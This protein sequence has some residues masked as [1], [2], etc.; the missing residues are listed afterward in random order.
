[1]EYVPK[2]SL[3]SLRE[4]NRLAVIDIL[5]QRG[6]AS[7]AEISRLTGLSRTTVSNLVSDLQTTGLVVERRGEQGP[8]NA[9]QGGRPPILLTLDPSAGAVVGIDFGHDDLRVAVADLSYTVLA[10]RWERFDVDN[11]SAGAL[12]AAERLVHE[13]VEE[14]R[15]PF[16]RVVGVGMALSAPIHRASGMVG[17]ASILPGWRS[18]HPAEAMGERLGMTVHMD[19]DAN[20]GAL[21]EARFGAGRGVGDL[22]FVMLSSGVGAGL[23]FSGELYRGWGGAAGEIGHTIVDEQGAICH[24]GNRGCLETQAATW[25]VLE[26]LRASHGD[27][28]SI[29]KVI[30][31]AS[32]GDVACQR[33]VADAGR[34]VGVAIANLVSLFNPARVIV[35]GELSAAGEIL[36]RP[37]REAVE[38]FAIPTAAREVDLVTGELGERAEVLGALALALGESDHELAR[39]L[40]TAEAGV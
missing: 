8:S 2:G 13:A 27:D 20:L 39:T 35:G 3:G 12:A 16:G 14:S 26:L 10:E 29:Q 23:L 1:V 32:D 24:C 38:R 9:P 37:L 15:V 31:L 17:S 30:G 11:D 19:N 40:A 34:H 25:A 4:R 5:K 22:A 36:M 33:V 28:L 7:R 6:T 21:A 18:I